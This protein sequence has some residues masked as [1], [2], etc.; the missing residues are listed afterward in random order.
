MEALGCDTFDLFEDRDTY[1][2]SSF[3]GPNIS[4]I[5]ETEDDDD[6][7][8]DLTVYDV[9]GPDNVC[10]DEDSFEDLEQFVDYIMG[11]FTDFKKINYTPIF[12]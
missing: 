10:I 2:V 4:F 1:H 8:I 5:V 12:S 7:T 11:N 9:S 3:A 6:F